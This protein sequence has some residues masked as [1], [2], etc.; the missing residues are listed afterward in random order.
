MRCQAGDEEAFRELY[1]L[2]K[3][4]TYRYL[5]SMVGETTAND[6]HQDIWLIIYKKIH[7]LMQ[8]ETF[9]SWLYRITRFEALDYIRDIQRRTKYEEIYSHEEVESSHAI[10]LDGLFEEKNEND[11]EKAVQKLPANNREALFLNF[12]EG[13]TYEEIALVT[14]TRIGTIRSRIYHAKLKLKQYL[15]NKN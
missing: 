15:E 3:E 11:L 1:N 7:E 13:L 14:G 2:Y 4:G 5:K 10:D 12:Y 9:T 8:P 6:L